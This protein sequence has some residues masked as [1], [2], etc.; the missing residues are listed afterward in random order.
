MTFTMILWYWQYFHKIWKVLMKGIFFHRFDI[1]VQ[2]EPWDLKNTL[3]CQPWHVGRLRL[4]LIL[5]TIWNKLN[6]KCPLENY[7]K[8]GTIRQPEPQVLKVNLSIRISSPAN[9]NDIVRKAK[10]ILI[11]QQKGKISIGTF[12]TFF[13]FYRRSVCCWNKRYK[14]T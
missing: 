5:I 3:L 9:D 7:S 11:F 10:T 8:N 6:V 1:A 4:N 14:A 13:S 12:G 2:A